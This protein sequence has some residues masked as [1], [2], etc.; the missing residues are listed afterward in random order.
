[1]AINRMFA[2]ESMFYRQPNAS[3]IALCFLV[4]FLKAQKV[5]WLDCQYMTP[6]FRSFGAREISRTEFMVLLNDSLARNVEL[7]R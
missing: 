2:G 6:L 5:S 7:F 3:K 4:E 1:M